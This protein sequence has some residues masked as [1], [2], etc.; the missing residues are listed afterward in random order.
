MRPY[1]QPSMISLW[2]R[3]GL[4]VLTLLA[5]PA[6]TAA[7]P[8]A[9]ETITLCYENVEVVPW[10]KA[11]GGGLNF[12]LLNLVAH[13]LDVTFDYRSAPWKRC[14]ALIKGNEVG[15]VF[16]A[17]FLPERLELA[18]YPGGSVPDIGKRLHIDHFVMLR[19][20]GSRADWD[21][22][23]F[24][25]VNGA[26]GYQLGYSIGNFLRSKGMQVDEG[27]QSPY[28]LVNKLLAGRLAAVAMGNSDA[29]RVMG[30]PMAADLEAIPTPL[31][32]KPYY[33]IFSHA[34]VTSNPQLTAR[35][36]KTIEDVR[37]GPAYTKLVRDAEEAGRAAR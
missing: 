23:A 4:V 22:K 12:E 18:E 27:T 6:Q 37:N 19:K 24:S 1:P 17:S 10:R 33:L 5:R 3:L 28:T 7:A 25:N 35:I 29:T 15:G 8:P 20:K 26:I 21:G 32:E 2:P 30:G 31:L 34:L 16:A 11:N 14:L 9:K 13:Q 36:W